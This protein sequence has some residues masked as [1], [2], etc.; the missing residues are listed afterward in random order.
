VWTVPGNHENFGI[1][2]GG[3]R[4]VGYGKSHDRVSSH[5]SGSHNQMLNDFL[6]DQKY[7]LEIAGP[8]DNEMTGRAVETALISALKP[9]CNISQGHGN[10]RFRPLGIPERFA[11]R[12]TLPPLFREDLINSGGESA[13]PLLFVRINNT[14][15]D[16]GRV[17][18][19]ASNPPEDREILERLDGWWQLN[20][21]VKEWGNDSSKSPQ[22]LLGVTLSDYNWRSPN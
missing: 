17:G 4:Y 16:D 13:Y 6:S 3:V 7:S 20:S 5:L 19:N 1:E 14:D 15:F 18:Y 21:Y 9:D 22:T 8:F 11:E 12:L 10:W 2:R